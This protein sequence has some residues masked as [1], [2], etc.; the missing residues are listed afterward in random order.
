M[1][2]NKNSIDKLESSND[3]EKHEEDQYFMIDSATG[4]RL[5]KN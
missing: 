1:C 4:I 2:Y 5:L 3:L